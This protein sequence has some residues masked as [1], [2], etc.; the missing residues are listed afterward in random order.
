MA[1]QLV[2]KRII[3]RQFKKGDEKSLQ[4]NINDPDIYK[5][6]LTIPYPYTMENAVWWVK[7]ANENIKEKRGYEL[8]IV[9]KESKKEVIGGMGI[10]KID[11]EHDSA[12]VGYWLGK[13]YWGKGITSEALELLMGFA[14]DELK[15]HR[16][17]ANTFIEN[18]ASQRV[19]EKAGFK[20]EGRRKEV[21]KKDGKYYDDFIYGL[22]SSD[23]F[24][25]K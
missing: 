18:I 24:A 14:F 11:K 13:K 21:I 17:Y 4:E 20:R 22:V 12:E 15:L 25:R 3:L 5:C 8:G 10:C 1:I 2:G 16:L 19:L 9:L 23:Y 7:H 6:T